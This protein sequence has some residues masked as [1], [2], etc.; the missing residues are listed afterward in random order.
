MVG[1][2]LFP[3]FGCFI[4]MEKI[5]IIKLMRQ[6]PLDFMAQTAEELKVDYK[7]KKLTAIRLFALLLIGFLRHSRL[8]QRMVCEQSSSVWLDEFLK[9][10]IGA[11]HLSHSSIADRL[12]TI[13]P[14]YFSRVYEELLRRAEVFIP[15]EELEDSGIIRI[16][17]TMVSETSAR[18]R[19][20][21]VS[22]I[23][24]RFGGE[25]KFV[26]YGIAYDG[27]SSVFEEV[28]TQQHASG[29]E[30][31]LGS[32]VTASI[33]NCGKPGE[34]F[35]FDRGITSYNTLCRIRHLC[36][37]K[38]CHF[39]SRLKLGRICHVE[40]PVVIDG[41]RLRDDEFEI[42]EDCAAF[43]NRPPR[44]DYGKER[45]RIIR[46]RF[47]RPRPKTLPSA[48]RRRYEP[49]MLLITDDFDA[50]PLTIA[51]D[52]KKRWG[53]EVFYKFMKQNLSF[54]HLL[55]TSRNGIEVM[56]YMTLITAVL[57]KIY[58][59]ANK[60][61]PTMALERMIVQIE[62]WIYTHPLPETCRRILK[63]RK[64]SNK[65]PD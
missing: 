34:T 13:S 20:G 3:V 56:L 41:A 61:G 21:I 7:A 57:I 5:D 27:F 35:V 1:R 23:N 12:S 39:V 54:S 44:S 15:P 46:V 42:M 29:D 38:G 6:L 28:F 19:E 50:E 36:A 26:K 33:E 59:A 16:D 64:I 10:D 55:S 31:A 9:I 32:T 51:H 63:S 62:N 2:R 45:F 60:I 17:T 48:R 24:K 4:F 11:S 18:L 43:L 22:G 37:Q 30:T 58:A 65:S 8:S 53:I 47:T 40:S 52:Y 25:K 49:E 14:E